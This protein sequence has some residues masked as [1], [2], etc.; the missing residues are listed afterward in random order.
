MKGWRHLDPPVDADVNVGHH[1]Q[2]GISARVVVVFLGRHV[3]VDGRALLRRMLSVGV[4]LASAEDGDGSVD[5]FRRSVDGR[6]R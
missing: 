3:V 2:A 5:R 4:T 1:G 6:R